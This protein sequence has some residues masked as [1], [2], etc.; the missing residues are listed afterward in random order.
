MRLFIK[1]LTGKTITLNDVTP[2][3]YIEDIKEG[4]K[5]K[6]LFNEINLIFS[7]HQKSFQFCKSMLKTYKTKKVKY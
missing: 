3:D 1:T 5:K 6:I 2:N 7:F 4:E